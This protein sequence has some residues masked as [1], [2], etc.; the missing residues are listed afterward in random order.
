MTELKKD[1]RRTTFANKLD[2]LDEID[3]FLE[4][5]TYQNCFKKKING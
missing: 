5:A 4:N 3:K 1:C 2:S